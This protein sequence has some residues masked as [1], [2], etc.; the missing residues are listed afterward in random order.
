[1]AGLQA[2]PPTLAEEPGVVA[3]RSKPEANSPFSYTPWGN[4]F[5]PVKTDPERR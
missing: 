2:C 5:E 1:M 3:G 4:P